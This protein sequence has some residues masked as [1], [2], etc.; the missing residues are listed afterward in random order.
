MYDATMQE[1]VTEKNVFMSLARL[2]GAILAL[3]LR[4]APPVRESGRQYI[5]ATIAD[6]FPN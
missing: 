4:A 1:F 3:Y 5:T 2:R 6:Q